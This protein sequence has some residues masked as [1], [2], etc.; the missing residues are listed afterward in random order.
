MAESRASAAV[1]KRQLSSLG[2]AETDSPGDGSAGGGHGAVEEEEM[3]SDGVVGG[4]GPPDRHRALCR[5]RPRRGW[6]VVE[7]RPEGR[8]SR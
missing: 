8:S 6:P 7:R 1:V 5:R 2:A 3:G 4:S